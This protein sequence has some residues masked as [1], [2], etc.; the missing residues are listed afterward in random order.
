MPALTEPLSEELTEVKAKAEA[1]EQQLK[2]LGERMEKA[3][4]GSE[5]RGVGEEGGAGSGLEQ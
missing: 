3:E 4:G 1:Q 5:E 2:E